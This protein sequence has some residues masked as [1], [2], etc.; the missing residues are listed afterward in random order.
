VL[1]EQEQ[2]YGK[3]QREGQRAPIS[4][5]LGSSLRAC[6]KIRLIVPLFNPP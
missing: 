3:D 1:N 6:A 2:D 5:N 4:N